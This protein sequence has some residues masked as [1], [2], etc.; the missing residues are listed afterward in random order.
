[1]TQI[2][3]FSAPS[4][5]A[6]SGQISQ[7]SS[8]KAKSMINNDVES[9]AVVLHSNTLSSLSQIYKNYQNDKNN[10]KKVNL[11]QNIQIFGDNL[12]NF[13]T[14]WVQMENVFTLFSLV[15]NSQY[16]SFKQTNI[17]IDRLLGVL[18]FNHRDLFSMFILP[19]DI[20]SQ[21]NNQTQSNVPKIAQSSPNGPHIS[22]K[23][24]LLI[25]IQY[26]SA[27]LPMYVNSV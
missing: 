26:Q 12:K 27:M 10:T 14:A 13:F 6:Q 11:G 4:T 8:D 17:T 16:N 22:F 9:P 24:L 2:I 25:I 20:F 18:L 23:D 15:S 21:N 7:N 3:D 5:P 1:M 19:F